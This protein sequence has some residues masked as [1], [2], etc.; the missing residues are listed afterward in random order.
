MTTKRAES[1][2]KKRLDSLDIARLIAAALIIILHYPGSDGQPLY[3]TYLFLGARIPF[4]FLLAGFFCQ[5]KS[6]EQYIKRLALL[7]IP[8]IIWELIA[9]SLYR[10]EMHT[11]PLHLEKGLIG[12]LDNPLNAPLWFLR[13]LII[14][15]ILSP[16]FLKIKRYALAMAIC[17]FTL[18]D[19]S[20]LKSALDIHIQLYNYPY[21]LGYYC[22]GIGLQAL[23]FERIQI[24]LNRFWRPILSASLFFSLMLALTSTHQHFSFSISILGGLLGILGILSAAKGLELMLPKMARLIIHISPACYLIFL[25]HSVLINFI[26]ILIGGGIYEPGRDIFIQHSWL[27]MPLIGIICIALPYACIGLMR[28]FSPPLLPII[29]GIKR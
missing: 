18:A 12:L 13:D 24:Y 21:I 23:S 5:F 28:R 16:L 29:A 3:T 8:F 2:S 1:Q 9:W 10:F 17:F 14:L 22:L 6:K 4:F 20:I 25:S 26:A 19:L 15:S 11:L 7:I 27:L